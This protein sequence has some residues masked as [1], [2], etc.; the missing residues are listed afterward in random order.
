MIGT[1]TI[2]DLITDPNTLKPGRINIIEA[3][4]SS[5]KTHFAL[6][7]LP[8][9]TTSPEKILY[10]IDTLNGEMHIQ[11]NILARTIDRNLYAFY[12]YN[13]KCIWGDNDAENLMP[14]MTYQGFGS[15]LLKFDSDFKWRDF[16]FIICDEM[17]N[18]VNY[19]NIHEKGKPPSPYLISAENALREIAR[20]GKT[21]I[22]AL[23]A[24]PEEI[25]EHFGSLCYEVPMDRSDIRRLETFHNIPYSGKVEEILDGIAAKPAP[26]T[27]ILYTTQVADMKRYI[28][29]ANKIGIPA[30]GFWSTNMKTQQKNPFSREQDALLHTVLW[31]ETIPDNIRL[32]VINAASETCIKI[33]SEK[34]K[35]DYMIVH[36]NH[37]EVLTQVRGRYHGDLDY[38]YYH[39]VTDENLEKAKNFE[40]PEEL[41]GKR[42]YREEQD[43]ICALMS[44]RRPKAIHDHYKWPTV[45]KI[46]RENGYEVSDSIKDS[47]RHGQ[48]YYIV[49]KK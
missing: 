21:R 34:R 46:L 40:F 11:T 38:F 22:V 3:P 17:Q 47:K 6:S 16:D 41:L 9:W 14:V 7:V 35:V 15:E 24:T 5:G 20:M 29:Y 36:K 27:G 45:R 48:H 25:Y 30:N 18:L 37:N 8:K 2:T 33:Q 10:L 49:E 4:V 44:M 31:D 42:L 13:H 1:K 39:S 12:D 28:E 26:M 32:L 23:S 43:H 19:K